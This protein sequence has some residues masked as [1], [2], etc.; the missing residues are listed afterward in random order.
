MCD[1]RG[2]GSPSLL[3]KP[4]RKNDSL[5]IKTV[6]KAFK[7]HVLR[8][9]DMETLMRSFLNNDLVS[10]NYDL[11]SQNEKCSQHKAKLSKL[12]Y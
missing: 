2:S 11:V 10:Q 8:Y 9:K 5:N 4:K 6:C 7:L 1:V 3:W 12:F